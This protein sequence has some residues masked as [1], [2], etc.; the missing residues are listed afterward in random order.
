[1][2]DGGLLQ[3]VDAAA[4][5]VVSSD[6]TRDD[7]G[8]RNG[9]IVLGADSFPWA[10]F[11]TP[12]FEDFI[13]YQCHIGTFAGWNDQFN[14]AWARLSD[15][16]SSRASVGRWGLTSSQPPPFPGILRGPL[17]GIRPRFVFP[18]RDALRLA[19]RPPALRRCPPPAGPRRVLRRG[20]QPHR[21]RRQRPV[22]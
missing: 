8:S 6:L 11:S 5:A 13:V 22:G 9:S 12:R 14:K 4:R 17:M 19:L 21:P 16:E 15:V 3:Q 18:P 20:V 2:P 1:K 7:P 10:P